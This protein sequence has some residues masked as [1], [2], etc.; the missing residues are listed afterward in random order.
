MTELFVVEA[1]VDTHNIRVGESRDAIREVF[2]LDSDFQV[3]T[4][5]VS[6]LCDLIASKL[7]SNFKNEERLHTATDVVCNMV[8]EAVQECV[9]L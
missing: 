2:D 6:L 7:V 3:D 8:K 5:V 4:K 9:S 1:D